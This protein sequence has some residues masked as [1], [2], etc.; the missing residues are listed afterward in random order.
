MKIFL[1]YTFKISKSNATGEE[2]TENVQE[3]VH[4][5]VSI[6]SRDRVVALKG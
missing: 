4:N 5:V 1:L 2:A 6:L 3:D